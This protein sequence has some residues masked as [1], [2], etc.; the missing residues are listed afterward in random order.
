LAQYLAASKSPE[1]VPTDIPVVASP[2]VE[3]ETPPAETPAPETP[4]EF[5]NIGV[6]KVEDFVNI[7]NI[8][9]IDGEAVGKLYANSAATV[10]E[11]VQAED[12]ATW[13]H[14]QSG[15]VDGYIRSDYL[16]TGDEEL[17]KSIS[18]RVVVVQ[19]DHLNVR[20]AASAEAEVFTQA[21]TGQK[22]ALLEEAELDG[23]Y[24]VSVNGREGYVSGAF[25]SPETSFKVAESKE[26][27]QARLQAE[28]AQAETA[29]ADDGKTSSSK[30]ESSASV[31]GTGSS[32]VSYA[33]QFVGNRYVWG[34]TSL[35]NGA[36]CSGF[37]LSV[38]AHYGKSLPHSS[39]A[40]RGVGVS[41]SPSNM[42]PGDIVC[43][44]GHVGI[45][46][47]NG[48]IVNALNSKKGI[49]YTNVNF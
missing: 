38:F 49:T 27:E 37:V 5:A 28:I 23:W 17:A 26:E 21:N 12:G 30:D 32:V 18:Q 29:Q 2:Q 14:V 39:A 16:L 15:N 43:Y 33:S 41:V 31:S 24:K 3:T 4:S 20:V 40:L 13:H 19:T 8:P 42:Q 48:Q 6:S 35:T 36:D 10:L 1:I 47:G 7:R 22:L 25:A 45:Y 34:G 44:S 9:S 46:A 11:S